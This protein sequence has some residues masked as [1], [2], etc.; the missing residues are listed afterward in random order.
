M[1]NIFTSIGNWVKR[2]KIWSTIIILVII[3]F[4]WFLTLGKKGPVL[5]TFVSAEIGNI[6]EEV[7][8]T[9]NVKPLSEVDLAFE[10]GGKIASLNVSVGTKVYAGQYLASVS[11]ADL[12]ANLDQAKANLKKVNAGFG[13]N[14]DQVSLVFAQAKSSLVNTIK[15][16]YT[17]A[18]DALRNKV[19][20][21]FRDPVKYNAKLAF[22]TD[23][24]LQ[25]DI[26]DAKDDLS[27]SLDSWYRILSRTDISL[28]LETN[29]NIAKTN[30][31]S[32]KS[33]LD[34]C[35]EAVNGLSPESSGITQT[36]ID[37]WKLNVSTA[38]TNVNT[39]IDTLINSYNSYNSANLSVKISK[40]ST[41]AEEAGIEQAQASVASTEAELSKTIIRSPISGIITK[42]DAKL[43]EIIS[44]NKIIISVISYGDYEVETFVPEADISKIKIGDK[45]KTTLDAY[46]S[47]IMFETI[48][49][50]VDPA[51]TVIDGVPTYK[52]ILKFTNQDERV[53][54]GMTANLDIL[55]AE[56]IDVLIVPARAVYTI[57]N[58]KY[59]KILDEIGQ[60]QEREVTVGLRG[61]DGMVEII[62]GLSEGE[63][64]VTSL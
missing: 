51:A 59:I 52:V 43:G 58:K 53:R 47:D 5:P 61:S 23:T 45:A 29:Y 36:Q 56:K 39:A 33:I 28:D 26:E 17:K 37:A 49:I 42:V 40:N 8:V 22:T 41:L 30:L 10:R 11:N 21:L 46:N 4:I 16:S 27:D 19:Y 44:A 6:Q 13:D 63:K 62:S 20:S 9:G 15:D 64:A 35:A 32:I 55:T 54:A 25:E 48:V 12:L 3:G 57:D 7:S 60:A 38:R 31:I 14:A 50:R 34:K 18:D 24:F 2:H 1:K